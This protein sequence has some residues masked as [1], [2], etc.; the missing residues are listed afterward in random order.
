MSFLF[1]AVVDFCL[2]MRNGPILSPVAVSITSAVPA[3][4]ALQ[5]SKLYWCMLPA[6]WQGG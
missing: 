5:Q 6:R 4:A 2:K 3:E 1:S